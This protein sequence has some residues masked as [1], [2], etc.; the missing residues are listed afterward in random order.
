MRKR[1]P[2]AQ[3]QLLGEKVTDDVLTDG[4][5]TPHL[6]AFFFLVPTLNVTFF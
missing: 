1:A 2:D 5:M 6:A 3:V 4:Q